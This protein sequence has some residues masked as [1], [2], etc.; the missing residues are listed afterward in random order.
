MGC[1]K[2]CV[3]HQKKTAGF[4][5]NPAALNLASLSILIFNNDALDYTSLARAGV[6]NTHFLASSQ[7]GGHDLTSAINDACGGTQSK[8]DRALLAFHHDRL[9]GCVRCYRAR[10]IGCGRFCCSR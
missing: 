7:W 1:E 3:I 9:P 2:K 4:T 8:A 6:I 10:G 5:W